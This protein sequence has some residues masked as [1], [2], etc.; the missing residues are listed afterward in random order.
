MLSSKLS[1]NF[2]RPAIESVSIQLTSLKL[3]SR[4][5]LFES[6][7]IISLPESLILILFNLFSP[8]YLASPIISLR[9]F[10]ES[11]ANS[12]IPLMLPTTIPHSHI[13]FC[14]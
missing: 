1:P 11:C 10:T 3:Y 7:I 12:I 6:S 14:D 13:I 4:V 5:E 8:N 2:H 9:R